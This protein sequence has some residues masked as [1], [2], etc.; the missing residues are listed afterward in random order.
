M[1]TSRSG[2]EARSDPFAAFDDGSA[3]RQ[4]RRVWEGVVCGEG[5]ERMGGMDVGRG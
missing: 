5:W 4:V 2:S 3:Q 1:E